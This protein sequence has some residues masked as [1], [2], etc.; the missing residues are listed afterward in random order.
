[1]DEEL[2]IV[3]CRTIDLEEEELWQQKT[4]W[5]LAARDA[6]LATAIARRIVA[7][8][9][10]DVHAQLAEQGLAESGEFALTWDL[11]WMGTLQITCVHASGRLAG[12]YL[13]VSHL[14]AEE[15]DVYLDALLDDHLAEH[16]VTEVHLGQQLA[17]ELAV[18]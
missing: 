17:L 7:G 2:F 14:S 12:R 13:A 9:R 1:M 15:R 18:A 8:R 3:R 4:A 6:V 10:D 11:G 16:P 5:D